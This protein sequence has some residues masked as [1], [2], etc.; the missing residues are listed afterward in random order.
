VRPFRVIVALLLALMWLPATLHCGLEA[1]GLLEHAES[2]CHDEH[3]A[4]QEPVHCGTD[5]CGVVE[6]GD[7]Q[8]VHSLVKISAPVAVL[9]F[10]SLLEVV[11][12]R[13][14]EPKIVAPV[15]VESPPEIRRTWHFVVRAAPSPRAPSFV[16]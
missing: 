3:E 6:S 12:P 4:S 9:D 13:P 1:A 16:A 2:C 7:Y 8:P 11:R 10:S 14:I 5:N 15:D